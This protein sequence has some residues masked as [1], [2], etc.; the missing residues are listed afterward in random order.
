M[1]VK[2][3]NMRKLIPILLV[4]FILTG[5]SLNR[6]VTNVVTDIMYKGM[7]AAEREEDEMIAKQAAAAM[8]LSLE[9]FHQNHPDNKKLLTLMSQAYAN[10]AFGFSEEG[11]LRYKDT[12]ADLYKENFDRAL[13][14][15]T[16]GKNSGLD[17]LSRKPAF[18]KAQNKG[19][20]DFEKSLKSFSKRQISTLFWTG[21]NW[22][23][24][25]NLKLDDP[26]AI[27]QLPKAQAVMNRVIELDEAYY[28]GAAHTFFGVLAAARPQMLGGSPK[29]A[30]KHFERAIEITG[31][32]YLMSKVLFAQFYAVQ[33]QDRALF[34]KLL[35][36]VI[37]A[38][39]DI[40]P[41]QQLANQIAKT[42]ASLLLK[43]INKYF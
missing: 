33:I 26:T 22:G 2:G 11:M 15:Y 24:L 21:F 31:G 18:K 43:R 35:N 5:C 20:G 28:Y 41:E 29:E 42:R 36:E 7:P 19:F 25:I 16:R 9:A 6:T 23:A 14:F 13:R 17:A 4:L 12:D 10:Y 39:F 8:L 27:A 38:P 3:L 32:K 40:L 1:I 34:I 37:S 30:L